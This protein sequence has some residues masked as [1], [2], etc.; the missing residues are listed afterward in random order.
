MELRMKIVT[1]TRCRPKDKTPY[2]RID[3]LPLDKGT[4]SE[5][6]KGSIVAPIFVSGLETFDKIPESIINEDVIGLIE[7]KGDTMKP[8]A[9]L[10]GIKTK[11]GTIDLV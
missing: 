1:V 10:I 9:T 2:T 4:V 6:V 5:N 11:N 8:K 7:Y 3:Y